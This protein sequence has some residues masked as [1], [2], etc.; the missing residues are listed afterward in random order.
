VHIEWHTVEVALWVAYFDLSKLNLAYGNRCDK[1]ALSTTCIK[2][3]KFKIIKIRTGCHVGYFYYSKNLN[4]SA[5]NPQLG[6]LWPRAQIGHSWS[7][8]TNI[9]IYCSCLYKLNKLTNLNFSCTCYTVA[10][11]N[12]SCTCESEHL[13][14]VQVKFCTAVF[15]NLCKN[16]PIKS[17]HFC[18]FCYWLI[19]WLIER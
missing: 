4:W 17:Y 1:V 12:S 16:I 11:W 14:H 9:W 15:C 10:M 8:E 2:N 3:I 6:S 13:F 18:L 7:E 5:Q 19:L